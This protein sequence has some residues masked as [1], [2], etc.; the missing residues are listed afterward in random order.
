MY[1]CKNSAV[2]NKF[3][4]HNSVNVGIIFT[5]GMNTVCF[6]TGKH[7][8]LPGLTMLFTGKELV[9]SMDEHLMVLA[10]IENCFTTWMNT[11]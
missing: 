3:T 9:Y 11:E 8:L 1:F 6:N 4:T 2:T 10:H 7:G 5:T